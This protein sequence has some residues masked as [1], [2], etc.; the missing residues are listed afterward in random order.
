MIIKLET[1]LT[2]KND[3]QIN[4]NILNDKNT[5][6]INEINVLKKTLFDKDDKI[7]NLQF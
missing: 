3:L 6:L 2:S 5:V 7:S 4:H 1:E